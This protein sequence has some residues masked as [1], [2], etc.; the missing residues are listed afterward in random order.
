MRPDPSAWICPRWP[1][2]KPRQL[3]DR[4]QLGKQVRVITTTRQGGVSRGEYASFNLA[5]HVG[6]LA[7]RVTENRRELR[8]LTGCRDIQWLDQVHGTQIIEATATSLS[9]T[10]RADAAW[11]CQE[12]LGLAVLTADCLPVVVAAEDGGVVAIAHAGWRGLLDG[13]L[14]TLIE[15]LRERC[16]GSPAR[17]RAWIGPGIS[18]EA[19]EVG[20]EV[21]REYRQLDAAS[22]A[23]WPGGRPGRY[24]LDLAAVA[25]ALLLGAGVSGVHLSGVCTF[26][27]RSLYSYRRDRA[28]GRM[29]TL[30]WIA[31]RR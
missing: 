20:E 13:V 27:A 29:A 30:V 25:Q 19:Y 6:D 5:E 3:G 28:T 31:G 21:A 23:L 17:Y 9:T 16:G 24:Q 7:A 11:T 18:A 14:Q 15:T 2:E 10:P 8:A 1:L 22:G 26:A 12:G 4:G